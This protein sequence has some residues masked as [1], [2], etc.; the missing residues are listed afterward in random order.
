MAA[1]LFSDILW[2]NHYK[3]I[4]PKKNSSA[5]RE[6]DLISQEM[7]QYIQTQIKIIWQQYAQQAASL[8]VK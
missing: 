7:L 6:I 8:Q 3:N 2:I 4:P 5:G 1:A